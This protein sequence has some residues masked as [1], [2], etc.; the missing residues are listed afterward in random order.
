M[1]LSRIGFAQIEQR[2]VHGNAFSLENAALFEE[3]RSGFRPICLSVRGLA[4]KQIVVTD[5]TFSSFFR[6]NR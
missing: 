5:E 6:L 3:L 1:L 4:G 2:K